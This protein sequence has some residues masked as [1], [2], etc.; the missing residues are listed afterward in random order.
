VVDDAISAAPDPTPPNIPAAEPVKPAPPEPVVD[1]DDTQ[2]AGSIVGLVPSE[3]E[4]PKEEP[5]RSSALGLEIETEQDVVLRSSGA[6]EF[7][8]PDASQDLMD[9][10]AKLNASRPRSPGRRASD[11]AAGERG[12]AAEPIQRAETAPA[13]EPAPP[14]IRPSEPAA[15]AASYAARDTK[16]QSVAEFFRVLLLAR[17]PEGTGPSGSAPEGEAMNQ[18]GR[19]TPRDSAVSFD[20]FFGGAVK[21]SNPPSGSEPSK[22]DLDQFQSWLQ[23]LKR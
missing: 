1:Q 4:P 14:P 7:T 17:P 16:G 19:P 8:V 15:P 10:A 20:D 5:A 2:K 12:V 11:R 3:F 21:G 23:N 6:S 9:L 13:K 22:E 18:D